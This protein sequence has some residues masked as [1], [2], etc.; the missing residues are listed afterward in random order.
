MYSWL[1][2]AKGKRYFQTAL[3]F[4]L[5]PY[6]LVLPHGLVRVQRS[7]QKK[8]E[9]EGSGSETRAG[10][11]GTRGREG[12]KE[13]R[14]RATET[15]TVMFLWISKG[16]ECSLCQKRLM[17]KAGCLRNIMGETSLRRDCFLAS[18]PD[19]HTHGHILSNL[20]LF[21]DPLARLLSIYGQ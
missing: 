6:R 2:P 19:T 20:P 15:N 9:S 7:A 12:G 10:G 3:H 16:L 5:S 21:L 18:R 13:K 1:R 14:E 11:T 17:R 4:P 8:G